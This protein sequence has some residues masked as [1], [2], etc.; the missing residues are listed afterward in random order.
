MRPGRY[1]D[2]RRCLGEALRAIALHS[3]RSR[4]TSATTQAAG[5]SLTPL[6]REGQLRPEEYPLRHVHLLGRDANF[7][8]IRIPLGRHGC[9]RP[10]TLILCSRAG[11]PGVDLNP[12]APSTLRFGVHNRDQ[13]TAPAVSSWRLS[14]AATRRAHSPWQALLCADQGRS[15]GLG[16]MTRL[17][18]MPG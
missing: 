17:G 7:A 4:V 13:P 15:S 10:N 14:E 1:V 16:K 12:A 8:G 5:L 11:E 18:T 6:G 2:C 9:R 3:S